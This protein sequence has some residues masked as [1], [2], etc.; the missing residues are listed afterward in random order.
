MSGIK[1]QR[2]HWL[3][4]VADKVP[5]D[6]AGSVL[7]LIFFLWMSPSILDRIHIDAQVYCYLVIL[8]AIVAF[9]GASMTLYSVGKYRERDRKSWSKTVKELS[10]FEDKD[11]ASKTRS[12]IKEAAS[13]M[14]ERQNE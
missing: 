13:T 9:L 5:M 2:Q 14:E 1:P 6:V 3:E 11:V 4:K 7:V 8:G 12:L 10:M